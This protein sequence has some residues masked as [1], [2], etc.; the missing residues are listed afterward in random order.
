MVKKYTWKEV[1]AMGLG[2]ELAKQTDWNW[3]TE[4]EFDKLVARFKRYAEHPPGCLL[5]GF[6][7]KDNPEKLRCTCGLDK[8]K[9]EL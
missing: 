5:R 1:A 7:R 6:T 2:T 4:A 8:A 9:E 3:V